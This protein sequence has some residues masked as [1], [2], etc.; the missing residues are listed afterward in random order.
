M[1]IVPPR[2]TGM[3]LGLRG[4]GPVPVKLRVN[5]RDAEV[6]VEPRRTL[7]SVFRAELGSTGAKRGC[8]EATCGACTVMLDGEAVYACMTL[9]IE[10]E[11][12]DIRTV[13]GLSRGGSLHP[14]QRAFIEE[15]GYQCGF[16]TP[17]QIMSAVALAAL[18]AII[19]VAG[20]EGPRTFSLP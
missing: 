1:A 16:C 10:C 4:P 20:P 15:D 8:G 13:E 11:G 3:A 18:G 9:A 6:F 2:K 12:R 5:G 14:V 17:G 19:E 7:L